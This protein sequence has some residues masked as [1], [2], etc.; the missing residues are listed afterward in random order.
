MTHKLG[1]M[2]KKAHYLSCMATNVLQ[3][4]SYIPKGYIGTKTLQK[5]MSIGSV[6][7]W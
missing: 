3:T 7:Q 4:E 5:C 2:K 1:D 6:A